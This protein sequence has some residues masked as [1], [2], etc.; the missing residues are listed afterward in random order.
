M[1]YKGSAVKRGEWLE[2]MPGKVGQTDQDPYTAAIGWLEGTL[3]VPSK[4][5]FR[6][7]QNDEIKVAG[8]RIRVR[9]FPKR[10][11][12]FEPHWDELNVLY[13]DDYCLVVHKPVGLKVHPAGD[14][15]GLTLAN[16][17]AAHYAGQGEQAAVR[18]I[19]RLDEF[20]S[21]PVL[22]A[23]NEYAQLILDESMRAKGIDRTYAA[24]VEGIL[25]PSIHRIDAPI[26]RDRHHA[27][28]QRVSPGGKPAVTRVI[29]A[30]SFGS[31]SLVR[32]ELETG[33]THQI[34][35]HMSYIGHPLVGDTLYGGSNTFTSYQALHGE[36]LTFPHP[37]TGEQL[38]IQDP[39]P[40]Q[41]VDLYHKLS[42]N[43]R[44]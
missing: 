8:D 40:K 12:G 27:K 15:Q 25:D 43:P 17:V 7:K 10:D 32:L 20:T 37:L 14:G 19:H 36:S 6:L 4:L 29:R 30:E 13:E 2:L 41:F 42:G 18:H 34:R 22:Y 39:W 23:K 31:F 11:Y 21:G 1:S 26:G 3:Q 33:R 38:V 9:L 44:L 16:L 5:L 35:V 28:R 24:I